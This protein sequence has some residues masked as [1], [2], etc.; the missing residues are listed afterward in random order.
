MT[1]EVEIQIVEDDDGHAK[2]I[3]KNLK[4]GG[5]RNKVTRFKDGEDVLKFY[6]EGGKARKLNGQRFVMLLDI[7]MPKVDGIKVLR[8]MKADDELQKVPIIMITTTDDPQEVDKCHEL[9]CSCYI[10]K[11][12]NADRFIEAMVQLGLFLLIIEVPGI[13]G[14]KKK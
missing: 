12:V 2:L 4:R 11:P 14:A 1:N 8:R 7:R 9:G 3:E 6:F 10:K 5:I 13:N